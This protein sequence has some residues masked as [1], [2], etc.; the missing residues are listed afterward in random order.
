MALETVWRTGGRLEARRDGWRDSKSNKWGLVGA[1]MAEGLPVGIACGYIII[2]LGVLCSLE[3][4]YWQFGGS[5]FKPLVIRI[6][7]LGFCGLSWVSASGSFSM[8]SALTWISVKRWASSLDSSP[9]S[10]GGV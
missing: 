1:S 9:T 10:C 2:V 8:G 4:A 5:P 3:R 6:T 7:A